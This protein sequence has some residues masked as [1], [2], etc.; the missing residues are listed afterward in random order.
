M[1]LVSKL[2]AE[3]MGTF[4]LVFGG[5]GAAVLAAT[6]LDPTGQNTVSASASSV[7]PSRSA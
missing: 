6:F 2:G 4:V 7:S 3:F 1:K 5:T